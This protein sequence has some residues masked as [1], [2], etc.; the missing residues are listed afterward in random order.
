MCIEYIVNYIFNYFLTN[1][2]FIARV[3]TDTKGF[4]KTTSET[5]EAYK[6]SNV[7]NSFD[8]VLENQIQKAKSPHL[9]KTNHLQ[10]RSNIAYGVLK[11]PT[12]IVKWGNATLIM[13]FSSFLTLRSAFSRGL[14]SGVCFLLG[15]ALA[16]WSGK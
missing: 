6:W 2:F 11:H 3:H 13:S 7:S 9:T 10:F 16:S 12:V 4:L 5:S 8:L 15:L 14:I 1:E